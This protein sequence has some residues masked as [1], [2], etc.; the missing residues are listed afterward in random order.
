[1]KFIS[2]V[3]LLLAFGLLG[4]GIYRAVTAAQSQAMPTCWTLAERDNAITLSYVAID[5]AFKKH[6]GE[7][8]KIWVSD[9]ADQPRRAKAGMQI[10]LSAYH[11]ARANVREW[12]PE[13]CK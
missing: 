10:N 13:I 7:L 3:L 1:M 11:R 2:C 12:E 8:F 5:D 6:V 4:L 9:P